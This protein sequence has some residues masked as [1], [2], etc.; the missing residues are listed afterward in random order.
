MRLK[1]IAPATKT[2]SI[3]GQNETVVEIGGQVVYRGLG[4]GVVNV[5]N[6]TGTA[7]G[8]H[9]KTTTAQSDWSVGTF[10]SSSVQALNGPYC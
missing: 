5:T 1:W 4:K 9:M 3:Y 7:Y 10:A 2:V 8:F 6:N